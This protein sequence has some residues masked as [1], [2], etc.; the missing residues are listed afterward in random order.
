MLTKKLLIAALFMFVFA[1]GSL[2]A[3]GDAARGKELST[4]C[5]DC[6]GEDGKGDDMSPTLVGHEE[7]YFIEQLK[8]FK[9]GERKDE[10]D[11]MQM[12]TEDLSEQDMADLAAYYASLPVD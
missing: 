8:A 4:D 5:A 12:Y 6:H 10:D 7:S 1:A 11:T 9:S 3:G 2:Q